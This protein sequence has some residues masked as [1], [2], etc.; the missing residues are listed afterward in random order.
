MTAISSY[1][2]ASILWAASGFCRLARKIELESLSI[3]TKASEDFQSVTVV[4]NF[5]RWSFGGQR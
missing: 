2:W 1:S 3:S 4:D 5:I